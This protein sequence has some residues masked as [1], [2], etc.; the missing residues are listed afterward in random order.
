MN[1]LILS[2]ITMLQTVLFELYG[3]K[4]DKRMTNKFG[5]KIFTPKKDS[6]IDA[7][8]QMAGGAAILNWAGIATI[9]V[10]SKGVDNVIIYH[11]VGHIPDLMHLHESSA[12]MQKVVGFI[13]CLITRPGAPQAW[14]VPLFNLAMKWWPNHLVK[15]Y[16][17]MYVVLDADFEI[18]ADKY[19]A[20]K[21]SS[22]TMFM[23]L[24]NILA[25][26]TGLTPEAMLK[27][28]VNIDTTK[29]EG[30]NRLQI[31]IVQARLLSLC[32]TMYIGAKM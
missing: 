26:Q 25:K 30:I 5:V 31:E 17:N 27:T 21:T 16:E 14:A 3:L 1:D 2:F 23:A 6:I 7:A 9:I 19:A 12:P 24:I 11:E 28:V 18:R 20:R 32:P 8:M 15:K 10:T 13:L 4:R 22:L 29:L